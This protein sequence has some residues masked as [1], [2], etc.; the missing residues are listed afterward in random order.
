[1][2]R[3]LAFICLCFFSF[4]VFS[5]SS[6]VHHVQRQKLDNERPDL[7]QLR[8][9]RSNYLEN[10]TKNFSEN[11]FNRN[12]EDILIPVVFHVVHDN[13]EENISD[14]QIHESIVQLNEDFAAINPELVDVHPNF[15]NLVADV[16]FEFRL[17]D[18]DPNGEPTTGINRIQSELTYNGSDLALKQL[19]QWDPTMYL[20][21]WVVYSSDGGNGSAFA[22]YPADVD[23][24]GSIYDGV[25]SSYWA[26]GRTETAVWTHYKILTHEVGHWANLKHTWGDQSY[27]QASEGCS[28]DDGVEDTPNTIGNTECDTESITCGSQDNVQNYMDYSDCSSMFTEGQKT[29][30][31]AAMNSSVGGRNNIWSASNHNLVFIDTD[32][33][34]RI[35]YS[36][37]SFTE[38]D[39]NNGSIN[40]T[41][42]I[43]LIDLN[44]ATS[45]VLTPGADFITENIPL[46]TE[47]FVNV[48]DA[49]HAEITMTGQVEN[50]TESDGF[51]NL[52]I[53]F[54]ENPF[55]EVDYEDIYNP[56]KTN[57][58]LEFMD[59]YEIV[60]I[61]EIEDIHNFY[62]GQNWQ[63]FGMGIGNAEFGLWTFGL[64]QFKLE[65]YGKAAACDSGTYNLTPLQFGD[66]IYSNLNF[67]TPGSYPDQLNISNQDYNIWNGTTSYTAVTFSKNGNTHYAWIRIK[68]SE[69]GAQ[70]WVMDMAYNEAPETP[71]LAGQ[72]QSSEIAYSQT[73]FYES[74][75][76]EGSIDSKRVID[77]FGNTWADFDT[78]YAG[79]G[80]NLSAVPDGLTAML[81]RDSDQ[82]AI[83]SLEGNASAHSNS[84]DNNYLTLTFES[85]LF[86]TDVT[87]MDMDQQFSVDFK[88]AYEVVYIEE[89]GQVT[90]S[91]T[92][93]S[94]KWFSLG[95]GDADFGLWYVNDYYRLETYA[96]SGICQTGTSNLTVLTEGD[97]IYP[98]QNWIYTTE[99]EEQLVIGSPSY[100]DWNGQTAFAG[101]KFTIAEQ[102][103][104][105]WMRF[106]VSEAGDSITLLDYAYNARPNEG[107][108][109]GQM[110]ASYGCMDSL[111]LNYNPYAIEDNGS[112]EYPLDCGDE[113]Y[114]SLT[115]YDS[116]GDGWNNNYLTFLN[117]FGSEV[118]SF[119][120]NS[121]AEASYEFC[122]APDC[123]QYS[124]GG[125]SWT[126][127]I[128]WE[129]YM[130]YELLV[131]GVGDD[132]GLFSVGADCNA[133]IGCTDELAFNYNPV[134]IEEDGSCTY[135]IMGCTSIEALN[136]NS[137]AEEEDGSCYYDYDVLG[138]NDPFA[139]NFNSSA[140]YSDGS[141]EYP[142]L[143]LID[144][145][146]ELCMDDTILISW[147]GG[148]PNG[149]I[150]I[151]LIN[152]TTNTTAFQ[153]DITDNTG[154]Y[155]WLA[156][157]VWSDL[158]DT[159]RF[160]IQDYP[161]PPNSWSYGNEFMFNSN[162][163]QLGS[164]T[165]LFEQGWSM[166]STYIIPE[167]TDFTVFFAPVVANMIIAKDNLGAAYL[168]EW[169]F[170]GIGDI[171]QGQGYQVKMSSS[172]VLVVEGVQIQPE[173]NPIDL[174]EGW[175]MI[176]YLRTEAASA[177]IVFANLVEAGNIVIVKDY[178]GNAFLPE[179]S[180]NGIGDM[181]PG[182]GYQL[183]VNNSDELLYQSNEE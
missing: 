108:L 83:L 56:S 98:N 159:Y 115:T 105:G 52:E 22:Y 107:L 99:V 120:M 45:G 104:Y 142:S 130:D 39:L 95:V 81:V 174:N 82:T 31:L 4:S 153:I 124:G 111:A 158:E 119:T 32:T 55:V 84:N 168:P 67:N 70:C 177:D 116:Y 102:F 169:N 87:E 182:K 71:I 61:D 49:T 157:V 37:S 147:I 135:P 12:D 50:H 172:E 96:K 19:V 17:A 175:N 33:L 65:T 148:N 126:S 183:K 103:H 121:G 170:N 106:E 118:D 40:S 54:T 63:W 30:M 16:G 79:D 58:G 90:V 78:L 166:I 143:S 145:S 80:F 38:D 165:I 29:R 156:E 68:V 154:T 167:D 100:Q 43:E 86:N 97:S 7:I 152:V 117:S 133:Y 171:L 66:T 35:V 93:E 20:N 92:G 48:I 127:E 62:E 129:V 18:L 75:E 138:C 72:T 89:P 69:D 114:M 144:I 131:E 134:A 53:H 27:N 28:F 163:T 13:G 60:Y 181:L 137:E 9:S 160:Y 57:I 15:E 2:A 162:C 161:W 24:S 85:E 76:N 139:L 5:Q 125:G 21:I 11:Q 94:W 77:V 141:C 44:F 113:I 3:I 146:T 88:D 151:S 73:T 123:Y 14:A 8:E 91:L 47:I 149:L 42:S 51:S 36:T 74:V 46:G 176:A 25:V 136:Y 155:F 34:P 109:A 23:G 178:T 132:S 173:E 1:M 179:W 112:C 64:T 101:V 140:T 26:V 6:C 110:Y 122:L 150:S 128:S 164:Q 59:P 10:F 180:F 41:I